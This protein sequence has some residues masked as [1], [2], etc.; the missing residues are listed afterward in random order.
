MY[1]C[2]IQC[3]SKLV[4]FCVTEQKAKNLQ[5]DSLC[6]W[7]TLLCRGMS[8]NLSVS[9]MLQGWTLIDLGGRWGKIKWFKHNLPDLLRY[10]QLWQRWYDLHLIMYIAA[11]IFMGEKAIFD[12]T[13]FNRKFMYGSVFKKNK[14]AFRRGLGENSSVH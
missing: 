2:Y 12:V 13:N 11:G 3:S 5:Q 4:P 6:P 10:K 14:L 7:N 8:I 9:P 1:D